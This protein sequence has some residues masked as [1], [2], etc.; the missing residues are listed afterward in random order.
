MTNLLMAEAGTIIIYVVFAVLIVAMIIFPMFSN[1]KRQKQYNEMQ[2]SLRP[3]TKIMTIGRLI[4][5]VVKVY[6]DNTIELDIGTEGNPVI[7]VINREAVGVN[8]S[9]QPAPADKKGK[10]EVEPEV[11]A[12]VEEVA[13]TTEGEVSVDTV[14]EAPAEVTPP[15]AVEVAEPEKKEED[16]AI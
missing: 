2:N 7:I 14:V 16:D 8:L 15:E 10:K 3:G 4:G 11:S 13:P 6:S 1:K 5:T 9:A 12:P